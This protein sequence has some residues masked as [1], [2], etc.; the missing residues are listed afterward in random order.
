M[1]RSNPYVFTE[2]GV[3]MLSSILHTN[4]AAQIS[5]NIMRAFVSMRKYMSSTLLEQKHI[6]DLVMQHE[7]RLQI[8]EDTFDNFKEKRITYFLKDKY[9]MLI[10]YLL[11][12]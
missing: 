6:N 12:Y 3:A 8:I 7:K 4:V 2:Q 5:I 9:M 10:P 11:I 1:S